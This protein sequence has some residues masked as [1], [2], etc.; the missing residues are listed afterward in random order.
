MKHQQNKSETSPFL[1]FKKKSLPQNLLHFHF[2]R[3][4]KVCSL[5][6]RYHEIDYFRYKQNRSR[7]YIY[8]ESITR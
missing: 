3:I 6:K 5:Q 1:F 2:L 8:K 7:A 4:C